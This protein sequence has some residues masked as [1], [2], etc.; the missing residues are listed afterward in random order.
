MLQPKKLEDNFH[1]DLSTFTPYR[2]IQGLILSFVPC[3]GFDFISV[4]GLADLYDAI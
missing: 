1:D 3:L 4:L 2:V